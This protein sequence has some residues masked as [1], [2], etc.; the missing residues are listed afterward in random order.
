MNNFAK[1]GIMIGLIMATGLISLYFTKASTT[2]HEIFHYSLSRLLG[3]K[4]TFNAGIY[5]GSTNFDCPFNSDIANILIAF[6]S[7][8][9]MFV[10]AMGIWAF[11]GENSI[12][13]VFSVIAMAYSVLPSAFTGLVGSDA[14]YILSMGFPKWALMGIMILMQGSFY[15]LLINEITDRDWF[16]KWY[17]G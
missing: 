14:S 15:Y 2:S 13:R 1:V 4:A 11:F 6:A 10:V 5:T 7:F 9:G 16:E 3:C 8:V 12:L 17:S